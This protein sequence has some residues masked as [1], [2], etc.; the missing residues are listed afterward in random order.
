MSDNMSETVSEA[1]SEA[2]AEQ[3]QE[4]EPRAVYPFVITSH[5]LLGGKLD[6]AA[7]AAWLDA[8]GPLPAQMT[9]ECV[10]LWGEWAAAG[11]SVRADGTIALSRGQYVAGLK[12][13]QPCLEEELRDLVREAVIATGCAPKALPVSDLLC[14]HAQ[15]RAQWEAVYA[16]WREEQ[17]R[18]RVLLEERA[19]E[20]DRKRQAARAER[21]ANNAARRAAYESARA[22]WIAEHGSER[23]RLAVKLGVTDAVDKGYR[24]EW[25]QYTLP[26]AEWL[27]RS[28]ELRDAIEPSMEALQLLAALRDGPDNY[29]EARLAWLLRRPASWDEEYDD[30]DQWDRC[31]V[32][33][34]TLGAEDEPPYWTREAFV[35]VSE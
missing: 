14:E 10:A 17:E 4:Q 6:N 11:A 34:L 23:L 26:P 25:R 32:V 8:H 19:L 35:R 3:E 2:V 29:P 9:V 27:R 12:V 22:A 1:V 18:A 31:M 30:D 28:D 21:E 24:D 5:T 7:R 33:L 16:A 13:Q 20:E 15:R